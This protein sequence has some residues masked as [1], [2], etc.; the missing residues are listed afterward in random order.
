MELESEDD[1]FENNKERE[2]GEEEEKEEDNKGDKFQL[3][4]SSLIQ[5]FELKKA[6]FWLKSQ[7]RQL[8]LPDL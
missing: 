8:L 1:K 2:K 4:H 3:H 7:S 5:L 6:S